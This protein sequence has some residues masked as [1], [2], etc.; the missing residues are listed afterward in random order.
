MRNLC[1]DR[2][3]STRA[4]LPRRTTK[5]PLDAPDDPLS[6]SETAAAST[7]SQRPS[8]LQDDIAEP[9]APNLSQLPSTDQQPRDS[10][11]EPDSAADER[12]VSFLLDASIYHPLS[13]LEVPG[14]FRRPFLP[15]PAADTI[16]GPFEQ[17]DALL[18]QCDFLR[19]A[20]LVGTILTSGLLRP[21]DTKTV[22]R[23]LAVRYSCLELSGNLPLAAQEAKAL[24]DLSSTFYYEDPDPRND[25]EEVD[26]GHKVPRHIM[27]FPLRLQALRLQSIGFSDPRRGVTTLYDL[28]FECREHLSASTTLL[29]DRKLWTQRLQEVS[30]RVVNA[31]IEMG[32]L[33]CAARTVE[34]MEP[35]DSESKA[36]WLSRMVLLRIKMGDL[37]QAHELIESSSSGTHD[38]LALESLLAIA[39]GRHDDAARSLSACEAE[40]DP[41]LKALLKQNLAVAHLYKGEVTISRRILEEL[42]NE[43]HSFQSL[44]INLAT[45]YDLTSDKARDLKMSM[46]SQIAKQQNDTSQLRYFTNADFKL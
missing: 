43:G 6:S 7:A 16:S 14:P 21:T 4:A 9:S 45:I 44:T 5:G 20:Q 29:E 36:L 32:E 8:S 31:L 17:L 24:E 13:Q 33:D 42:V 27:P 19:A 39:E 34:S 23:L 26:G 37:A 28:A 35:S 3:T 10:A 40:A 22:F 11:S 25:D 30:M 2:K 1:Y 15:P 41:T 38:K 18:S 46:V 12:D